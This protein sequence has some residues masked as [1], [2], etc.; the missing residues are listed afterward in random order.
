LVRALLSGGSAGIRPHGWPSVSHRIGREV[1]RSIVT[2]VAGPVR[3]V[4]LAL[5]LCRCR[6]FAFRQ[7]PTTGGRRGKT[8][9]RPGSTILGHTFEL[10]YFCRSK[11]LEC[12]NFWDLCP[13]LPYRGDLFPEQSA[14]QRARI[15]PDRGR[16]V[17]ELQ[18]VK[19]PVPAF[20]L[21]NVGGRL[22]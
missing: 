6:R 16:N 10:K 8:A 22:T 5:P 19:T 18:H 21:R 13:W 20:V 2:G 9:A 3:L 14:D 12:K 11:Y 1:H 17:Q 4:T 15:K 7:T